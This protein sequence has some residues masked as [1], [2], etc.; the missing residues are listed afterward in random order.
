MKYVKWMLGLERS[1][2]SYVV[3]EEQRVESLDRQ[4]RYEL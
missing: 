3:L 2:P 1:T 4:K